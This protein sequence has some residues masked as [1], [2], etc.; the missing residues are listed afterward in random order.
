MAERA[1][2]LRRPSGVLHELVD[3]DVEAARAVV[4][5]AIADADET[6]LAAAELREL[7]EL[8]G[9][10]FVAERVAA[11]IDDAVHAAETLGYPVVVKTAEAGAHKTE[12]GGVA[13]DLSDAD[14]VRAAVER[15]GA[16]VIVQQ[17]VCGGAELLAGVVQDPVF[18]PLVAFGPGGVFAELIGDAGFRIAPLT[19]VDA[20]ELVLGGKGGTLVRGFRGTPP[21]DVDALVELVQRLG[22]LAEDL[23]ELVELDLNP[24]IAQP[25]GCVVVDARARLVRV[26]GGRPVKGW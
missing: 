20:R 22:R 7:L 25:T 11:G 6:W 12:R 19:D 14:E 18:G 5:S 4:Q 17:Y 9:I 3:I 16:P 1:D 10:P 26:R 8:Y 15:I 13:L 23:P 21:A 24:V 2:W